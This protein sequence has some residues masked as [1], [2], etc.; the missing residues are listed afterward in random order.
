MSHGSQAGPPD[1]RALATLGQLVR[2]G[3]VGVAVNLVLYAV[4]LALA[5]AHMGPKAAMSVIY[6]AGVGLG[7]GLHRRWSFRRRDARR[8]DVLPYLAVNFAGYGLNLGALA[9]FVDGLG[10][11][12]QAVQAMVVLVVAAL[13]FVLQ[14]YW[15]CSTPDTIIQAHI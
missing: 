7:Y 11:P 5:S 8:R 15:V 9:L 4:Y 14:K 13:V 1:H 6:V 2:F 10:L 3:V 12:H